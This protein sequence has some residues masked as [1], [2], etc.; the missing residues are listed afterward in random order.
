LNRRVADLIR[1]RLL[2]RQTKRS[3]QTAAPVRL[4]AFEAGFNAE[5]AGESRGNG[6]LELEA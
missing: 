3:S 4:T 2:G 1:R 5:V 6:K